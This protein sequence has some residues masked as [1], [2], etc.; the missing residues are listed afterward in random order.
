MTLL[1]KNNTEEESLRYF[2]IHLILDLNDL[3]FWELVDKV[4]AKVLNSVRDPIAVSTSFLK[5]N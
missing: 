1:S 5:N 2:K 4:V 3:V